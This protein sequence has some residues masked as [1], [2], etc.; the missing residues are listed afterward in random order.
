MRLCSNGEVSVRRMKQW[1]L[2]FD[3]LL[4]DP[5]GREVFQKFLEKEISGENLHFWSQVQKL[6]WC[7]CR[8]VPILV[9]EIYK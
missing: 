3:D 4:T 2:S 8:M 9:T 6:R 1:G 7:S 5:Q